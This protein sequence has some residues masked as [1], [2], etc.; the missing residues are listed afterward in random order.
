MGWHA[1][2]YRCWEWSSDPLLLQSGHLFSP[3]PHIHMK[4]IDIFWR[5][6]FI[7]FYNMLMIKF[8]EKVRICYD[9]R[10]ELQNYTST[11]LVFCDKQRKNK[12]SP[13]KRVSRESQSLF[14]N[15]LNDCIKSL[16]SS[17]KLVRG[18]EYGVCLRQ[19]FITG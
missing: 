9:L 12:S 16:H 7:N 13:P 4:F 11:D 2:Y 3:S 15:T 17:F 1:T 10:L 14:I 19:V 5:T 18:E 8:S 6:S